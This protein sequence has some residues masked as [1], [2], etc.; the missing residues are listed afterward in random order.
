MNAP[1]R[2]EADLLASTVAHVSILAIHGWLLTPI[3]DPGFARYHPPFEL[4]IGGMLRAENVHWSSSLR[5]TRSL[6]V[7]LQ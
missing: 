2:R 6:S 5:N 7:A 4:L 3:P 1:I